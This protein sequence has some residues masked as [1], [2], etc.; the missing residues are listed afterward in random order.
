MFDCILSGKDP[1]LG[2]LLEEDFIRLLVDFLAHEQN[3]NLQVR[4]RYIASISKS[5]CYFDSFLF[6]SN[7]CIHLH[8]FSQLHAATIIKPVVAYSP[9]REVVKKYITPSIVVNLVSSK[10]PELQKEVDYQIK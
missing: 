8:F 2:E 7:I 10:D 3:P 5:N 4:Y 9:N 6:I 1:R